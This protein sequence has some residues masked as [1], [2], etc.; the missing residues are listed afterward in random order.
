MY[1]IFTYIGIILNY[2]LGVNVGKYSIHGSSGVLSRNKKKSPQETSWNNCISS[3]SVPS[4]ACRV[5]SHGGDPI[6]F[7]VVAYDG[8]SPTGIP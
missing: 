3:D 5:A 2:T 4:S 7:M 1:G 8:N 6:G